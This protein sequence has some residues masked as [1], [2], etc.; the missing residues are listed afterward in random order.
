MCQLQ[1][2]AE[3]PLAGRRS[4]LEDPFLRSYFGQSRRQV[5]N[6]AAH[7]SSKKWLAE[8]KSNRLESHLQQLEDQKQRKRVDERRTVLRSINEP[9]SQKMLKDLDLLKAKAFGCG[10]VCPTSALPCM[11]RFYPLINIGLRDRA[12][13]QIVPRW[14]QL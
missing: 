6:R 5:L 1:L 10:K 12:M 2:W 13:T 4:A 7:E 8:I 11:L 9:D 3:C 14:E